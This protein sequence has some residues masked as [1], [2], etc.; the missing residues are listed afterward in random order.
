MKLLYKIVALCLCLHLY[1]CRESEYSLSE[2]LDMSSDNRGE[3]EAVHDLYADDVEVLAAA[4]F[5][6]GNKPGHYSIADMAR[7][8]RFYDALD[9]LLNEMDD[10]SRKSVQEAIIDL[11]RQ[12]GAKNKRP[13][14]LRSTD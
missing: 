4:K 6:I 14:V 1:A 3:P 13:N 10:N 12:H 8:D 9:S 7:A 5:P 11:C 2:A